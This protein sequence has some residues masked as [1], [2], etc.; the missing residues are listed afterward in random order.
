MKKRIRTP[1]AVPYYSDEPAV[2]K[3]EMADKPA[4]QNA[5]LG[6][7][8]NKV[9][10][11]KPGRLS[12]VNDFTSKSKP[13]A[14]SFAKVPSFGTQAKEP[15]KLRMSGHAGAHRIGTKSKT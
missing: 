7:K 1:Q 9:V 3:S 14:G 6:N 11:K 15:A 13:R 10:D 8:P 2:A 5:A 12:G 4:V